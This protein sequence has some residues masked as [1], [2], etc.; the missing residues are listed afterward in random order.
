MVQLK[1]I[2]PVLIH[3]SCLIF[4]SPWLQRYCGT[5]V[6]QHISINISTSLRTDMITVCLYMLYQTL[7][8]SYESLNFTVSKNMVQLF[9]FSTINQYILFMFRAKR[10]KLSFIKI[11]CLL[12]LLLFYSLCIWISWTD[13]SSDY[14]SLFIVQNILRKMWHCLYLLYGI[15]S[16]SF[17]EGDFCE[18][19]NS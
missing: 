11:K 2:I 10:N 17:K 19:I 7:L 6:D 14:Y 9:A 1:V 18:K 15:T 5:I 4:L 13:L 3:I 12:L 8:N 16:A